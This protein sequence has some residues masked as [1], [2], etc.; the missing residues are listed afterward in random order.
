MPLT[1]NSLYSHYLAVNLPDEV[2]VFQREPVINI[3]RSNHEIQYLSF[4]ID[5]QMELEAKEP[6]YRALSSHGD[7]F[8]DLVTMLT[9]IIDIEMPQTF[10]SS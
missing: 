2:F 10:I 6:T 7:S 8:E 4:L 3:A 5:N 1:N 9:Y